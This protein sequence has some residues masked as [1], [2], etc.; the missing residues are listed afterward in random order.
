[1]RVKFLWLIGAVIVSLIFNHN[2]P[3][4]LNI[5]S[6]SFI[7][8]E[9]FFYA[10]RSRQFLENKTFSD[11][12]IWEHR[13]D[14]SLYL[15]EAIPT[16]LLA[17]LKNN[18]YLADIIFPFFSFLAIGWLIFKL[19]K[20]HY[21]SICGSILTIGFYNY[22]SYF[23]YLPSIINKILGALNQGSYS[24]LIRT[25]HP[26]LTLGLWMIFCGFLW[27]KL[28]KKMSSFLLGLSLAILTYSHFFY[29]TY[30]LLWTLIL[31]NFSSLFIWLILAL[32]YLINQ[33][34]LINL[35]MWPDFMGK[36]YFAPLPNINQISL[37]IFCFSLTLLISKPKLKRF[38][39]TFYSSGILIILSSTII[40]FG[41]DDPIGHWFARVIEPM[42]IIMLI[43][44]ISDRIKKIPNKFLLGLTGILLVYLWQTQKIYFKNIQELLP[45]ETN[46]IEVFNWLNHNTPNGSV[47]VTASLKDNIYLTAYTHNNTYISRAQT[48]LA[49]SNE[50]L[51]RFYNIY[52]TLEI[53]PD[54][55][56]EMFTLTEENI[57]LRSKKRFNF[58]NCGGNF[59]YFRKYIDNDY[60][61]CSIPEKE[62]ER[63]L[64][65]Y[66]QFKPNIKQY[67]SDYWL[68]GLE[69]NEWAEVNP[70]ELNWQKLWENSSY[71][72][73][74]INE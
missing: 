46:K 74:K 67:R 20:N 56:K 29:W 6:P 73:F 59:F 11:I 54:K 45:V 17:G 43:S 70:N 64:W 49:T 50:Q 68:W 32:P 23:P 51:N 36:I 60:Y 16:I 34:Q 3:L 10:S 15:G 69:E 4:S 35:P 48:S 37:I 26:Q 57:R 47:V 7:V 42:S 21:L 62:L 63:I 13:Q 31:G 27:M 18:F 24:L 65:E 72:I 22:L 1:M 38:W 52:K 19:T 61:N 41:A 44:L 12:A 5:L 9:T 28:N 55:I 30:G 71:K 2:Y 14:N 39:I 40:R 33:W 8:D 25:P 58:D 53:S 66:S